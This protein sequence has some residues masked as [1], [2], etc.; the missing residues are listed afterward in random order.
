MHTAAERVKGH[1]DQTIVQ[2]VL[3]AQDA[4]RLLDRVGVSFAG[5]KLV[6]WT[7]PVT[8]RGTIE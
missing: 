7:T 8:E 6:Y 2:V 4:N 3:T 1:A 5:T